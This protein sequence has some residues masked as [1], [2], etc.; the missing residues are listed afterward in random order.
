MGKRCRI[1]VVAVAVLAA[2]QLAIVIGLTRSSADGD[3]RELAGVVAL[4]ARS[5]V[6][7]IVVDARGEQ[8][9]LVQS[10]GRPA[11]VHVWASWCKPCR[12]ELPALIA[13]IP[14]LEDRGLDVVLASVDES[15]PVI[16]HYFEGTVPAAVVRLNHDDARS[17]LSVETMPT[18]VLVDRAGRLSHRLT[19]MQPWASKTARAQVTDLASR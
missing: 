9:S 11:I 14:E 17:L 10:T 12:E 5:S 4:D 1:I 19:G 15:W 2:I 18:T 8:R 6:A 7:G 16:D 13:S 3:T